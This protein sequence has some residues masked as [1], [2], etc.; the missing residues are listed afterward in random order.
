MNMHIIGFNKNEA[1]PYAIKRE[2]ALQ[3][4]NILRD[5]AED[6]QNG[7][8]YLPIEELDAFGLTE[9]DIERELVT[10]QWRDF[11]KISNCPHPPLLCQILAGHCHIGPG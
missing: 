1:I 11:M 10:D 3:L 7:R 6:W 2:V 9:A 8:L 4:T 5:I